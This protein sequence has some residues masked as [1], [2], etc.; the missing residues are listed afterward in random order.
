MAVPGA[1]IL[2]GVGSSGRTSMGSRPAALALQPPTG[3]AWEG[4]QSNHT[5]SRGA[6]S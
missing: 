1:L 4:K 3:G 6:L 2:Q 5:D